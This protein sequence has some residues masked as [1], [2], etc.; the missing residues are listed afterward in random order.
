MRADGWHRD[1]PRSLLYRHG[2]WIAVV[3]PSQGGWYW[4]R[5]GARHGPLPTEAAARAAA[6]A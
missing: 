2:V 1:G 5:F 3:Y 6:E 4:H